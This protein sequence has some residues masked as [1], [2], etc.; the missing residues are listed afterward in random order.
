MPLLIIA[1]LATGVFAGAA[2]YVTLVEHPARM[3]CGIEVAIQEFGP[4]YQRASKMQASLAIV[5]AACGLIAGWQGQDSLVIG[6]AL[7][8]GALVPFT[9]VVIAPTNKQLLSPSLD[10]RGPLAPALLARWG[11]LHGV[12]TVVSVIAFVLLVLRL[13]AR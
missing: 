9:L 11:V 5:G 2:V 13:A 8:I 10:R 3:S 7:L 6:A 12:R 4:S 1:T